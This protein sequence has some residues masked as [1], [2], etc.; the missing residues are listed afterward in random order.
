MKTGVFSRKQLTALCVMG[1]M[2]VG[3][4]GAGTAM[5]LAAADDQTLQTETVS[6]TEELG[7]VSSLSDLEKMNLKLYGAIDW[8][9][10]GRLEINETNRANFHNTYVNDV[11][12]GESSDFKNT[13]LTAA[14]KHN[15]GLLSELDSCR[16]ISVAYEAKADGY[17]TVS[18]ESLKVTASGALWNPTVSYNGRLALSVTKNDADNKITPDSTTWNYYEPGKT[19]FPE[20]TTVEVKA[21]DTVYLNMRAERLNS[22]EVHCYVSF[23]YSPVFTYSATAPESGEEIDYGN[24]VLTEDLARI[25]SLSDLNNTALTYYTENSWA[26]Y[27]RVQISEEKKAEHPQAYLNGVMI[28]NASDLELVNLR[29]SGLHTVGIWNE[30]VNRVV[31]I[32]YTARKSGYILIPEAPLSVVSDAEEGK[33]KSSNG[34]LGMIVTL[35][36]TK[37]MPDT[38]GWEYYEAG[39]DYTVPAQAFQ[40]SEGDT[41]YISFISDKLSVSETFRSYVSF[42]YDPSFVYSEDDPIQSS[43]VHS[44]SHADKLTINNSGE[45]VNDVQITDDDQTTYPFSYLDR[46]TAGSASGYP[47]TEDSTGIVEMAPNSGLGANNIYAAG[48]YSGFQAGSGSIITV[49]V[50]PDPYNVILGFTAPYDGELTISDIAFNYVYYPSAKNGYEF[51]G[52]SIGSPFLGYA[53]RILLNGKQVWPADGGWDKSLAQLFSEDSDGY[54][55]GDLKPN[56]TTEDISGILVRKYD[57]V[58]F[59]VTRADLSA[60]AI[61]NCDLVKFNPTFSIDTEADMS[62]YKSYL[63]ASDYFDTIQNTNAEEERLS[64]WY[65]DTTKGLYDKAEYALMND[66]DYAL[67]AYTSGILDIAAAKIGMNYFMPVKGRDA[68]LQYNVPAAGNLTVSAESIFRNGTFTLW[69]YYDLASAGNTP[70]G[71]D[72]VRLRIEINGQRVWPTD[73][74]WAEFKPDSENLGVFDFE[75]LTFG[76][77]AG[78][79]VAIRVNSGEDDSYDGLNFNPVFELAETETPVENPAI[80]VADPKDPDPVDPGPGDS[81]SDSAGGNDSQSG[82]NSQGTGNS[83]SSSSGGCGSTVSAAAMVIFFGCVGAALVENKKR[84]Q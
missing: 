64:Y 65:A 25:K 77:Q 24:V 57:T 33:E 75:S 58:Y 15:V 66:I 18:G 10:Y 37:T 81:S 78:D 60:N 1:A 30:N 63:T 32:G 71:A 80:T 51:Y 69:Q 70:V 27:T 5:A 7:K 41:I 40:V 3:T 8:M 53:F 49:A 84:K 38:I 44:F 59:E 6:L 29:S 12:V 35:N 72:G 82:N 42:R 47:G 17:I 61:Q 28:N 4:L 16:I 2:F 26:G 74:T 36:D 62:G 73:K 68:V 31:S 45:L 22:S 76:V 9:G 21:G 50:V 14:G 54:K 13:N 83:G 55:A 43:S 34:R 19:Y 48:S 39:K 11:K 56:Q 67:N 79:K 20:D 46:L 23:E 52:N